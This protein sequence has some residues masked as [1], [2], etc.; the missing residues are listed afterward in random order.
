MRGRLDRGKKR[1]GASCTRDC[2]RS[3]PLSRRPSTQ[4]RHPLRAGADDPRPR[5]LPPA[6]DFK[7]VDTDGFKDTAQEG[8]KPPTDKEIDF[9]PFNL[10]S[11]KFQNKR[12]VVKKSDEVMPKL[13][14]R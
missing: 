5:S 3:H 6:K 7:D 9:S 14:Q 1:P 13:V 10:E 8:V 2:G 11:I 4:G 12:G